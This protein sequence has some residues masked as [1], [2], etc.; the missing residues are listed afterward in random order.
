[1]TPLGVVNEDRQAS[2]DDAKALS[3][4]Q[5]YAD[6]RRR[7]QHILSDPPIASS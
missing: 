3:L 6:P 7:I 5:Q 1:M 4:L 2:A